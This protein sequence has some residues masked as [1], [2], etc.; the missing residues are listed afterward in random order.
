M[1]KGIKGFQKGNKDWDNPAAKL[2]Q[3]KKGERRS[4][5]T[6]FK[7]GQKSQKAMLGKKHSEATKR[8]MRETHARLKMTYRCWKGGVTPI[9]QL[10]RTSSRYKEWRKAVFE[11]DNYTCQNPECN[12]RSGD[13]KKVVLHADHIKPFALYPEL[14]FE[15]SNGRTLCK[16]CHKLTET[17]AGKMLKFIKLEQTLYG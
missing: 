9:N 5:K 11:R 13:G 7:K 3:F 17:Y 8:R 10:I 1:A 15:L 14:R 16:S 4:P 12:A 6:E 2:T